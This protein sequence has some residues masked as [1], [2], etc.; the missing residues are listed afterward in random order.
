MFSSGFMNALV[1]FLQSKLCCLV[2][3]AHVV[4][5]F[6]K[7]KKEALLDNKCL[8]LLIRSN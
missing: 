7:I 8:Y 1:T 3:S 4:Y 5:N 2:Y 6:M